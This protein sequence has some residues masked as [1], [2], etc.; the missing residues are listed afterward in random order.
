[1]VTVW[2]SR[3]NHVSLK[4][5]KKFWWGGETLVNTIV[6]SDGGHKMYFDPLVKGKETLRE[7]LYKWNKLE[8]AFIKGFYNVHILTNTKFYLN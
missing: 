8:Y 7:K 1:M 5:K 6:K 2:F 4:I 3:G